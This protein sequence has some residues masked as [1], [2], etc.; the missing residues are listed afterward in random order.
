MH[1]TRGYATAAPRVS[2]LM[3]LYNYA[4]HV[5]AALDSSI[6]LRGVD[7]EV[8]IVDD[9][10]T[11]ESCAAALRWLRGTRPGRVLLL[12]H[13][14][15]EGL[16]PTRNDA[17]DFARGEFCFVLDADNEVYPRGS[18]GSVES[19]DV[20][21]ECGLQPTGSTSGSGATSRS[22]WPTSC[23]GSRSGCA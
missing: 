13:P 21:S 4:H 20:D 15:N 18:L 22:G 1:R 9:G 6:A 14:V 8:V 5:T 2:V 19:L 11:D 12:A 7:W 10:S 16:G 3:A 17:L 23:R